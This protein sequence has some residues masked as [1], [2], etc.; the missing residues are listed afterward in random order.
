MNLL[1]ENITIV[2]RIRLQNWQISFRHIGTDEARKGIQ[3]DE[4]A[5]LLR[6][7]RNVTFFTQDND[8]YSSV[9]VSMSFAPLLLH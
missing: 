3:D 7:R 5:S 4:I 1:D 9:L 6:H 8:F 2:Q